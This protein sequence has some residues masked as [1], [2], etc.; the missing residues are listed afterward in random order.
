MVSMANSTKR[1]KECPKCKM[2]LFCFAGMNPMRGEKCS[3]CS[4]TYVVSTGTH[5]V[6]NCEGFSELVYDTL[7]RCAR[8]HA[9]PV[10][11]CDL[12]IPY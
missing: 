3:V 10:D 9:V 8:R 2:S 4:V 1:Y 6:G 11:V 5:I 7:E 12:C